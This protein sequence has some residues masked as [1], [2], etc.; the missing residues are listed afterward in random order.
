MCTV[1]VWSQC[2]HP[3][4]FGEML[5]WWGLFL[6]CAYELE[7]Y[8]YLSILSSPVW[9]TI[10]LTKI[11]GIPFL[12]KAWDKKWGTQQQYIQYRRNVNVLIP[13]NLCFCCVGSDDA[14]YYEIGN[15]PAGTSDMA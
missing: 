5:I 13:G 2:Q 12:R 8:Q 14:Q 10:L 11:S 7:L 15:P 1:G 4:Y 6:Y 9:I 3:N